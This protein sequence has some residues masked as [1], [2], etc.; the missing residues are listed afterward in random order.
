MARSAAAVITDAGG[1][2]VP[3]QGFGPTAY[4]GCIIGDGRE[5]LLA[6]DDFQSEDTET[7]A[8][9]A[10]VAAPYGA[11]ATFA[12]DLHYGGSSEAVTVYDLRTGTVPA[13]RGGETVGGQPALGDLAI[14]DS[15]LSWSHGTTLET[16]ALP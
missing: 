3:F 11:L 14:S 2:A 12:T 7:G 6:R 13:D 16:V 10:A 1:V 15:T 8:T 9:Q 5:R 4:L